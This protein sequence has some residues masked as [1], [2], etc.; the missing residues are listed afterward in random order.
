MGDDQSNYVNALMLSC[1][2][3]NSTAYILLTADAIH[4]REH[5]NSSVLYC[6]FTFA[7][8]GKVLLV[9]CV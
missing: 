6:E 8:K 5:K 7:R 2:H 3:E 4:L 9:L 1:M